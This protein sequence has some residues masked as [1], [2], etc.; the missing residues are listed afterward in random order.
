VSGPEGCRGVGAALTTEFRLHGTPG[1]DGD[2]IA[3]QG[4][5]LTSQGTLE[6]LF[7]IQ[8]IANVKDL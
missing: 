7:E 5:E 6:A 4:L 3:S 2:F 8:H 1:G